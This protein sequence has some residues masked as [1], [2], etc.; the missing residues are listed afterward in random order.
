MFAMS[1]FRAIFASGNGQEVASLGF[2]YSGINTIKQSSIHR[3]PSPC[4]RSGFAP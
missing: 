3:V 2:V 1:L 4:L